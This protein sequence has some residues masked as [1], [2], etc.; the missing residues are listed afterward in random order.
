MQQIKIKEAKQ[1]NNIGKNKYIYENININLKLSK[2]LNKM[3]I[4]IVEKK[5]K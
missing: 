4:N 5:Y 3:E 1:K 2:N